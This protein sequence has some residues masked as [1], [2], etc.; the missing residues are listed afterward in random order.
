MT[1]A[2]EE[3]RIPVTTAGSAGA[4]EGEAVSPNLN[5]LL[6]SLYVKF[7]TSA[8][9]TTDVTISEDGGAERTFLTLTGVNTSGS[10]APHMATHA[11][12][13]TEGDATQ[14]PP[15]ANRGLKVVVEGA[16]ALTDAVEVFAYLLSG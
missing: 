6:Y 13:G 7:H 1:Q 15:I 8:P 3:I 10:Y 12:D 4:A 16:D 14:W 2:F 11:A 9:V 5:G